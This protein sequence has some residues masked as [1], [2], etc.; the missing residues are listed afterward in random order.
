[1]DCKAAGKIDVIKVNHTLLTQLPVKTARADLL[2]NIRVNC[3]NLE[4]NKRM[5]GLFE[6]V[7]GWGVGRMNGWVSG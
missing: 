5:G 3:L 1:M 7:S 6:W 4:N 2:N